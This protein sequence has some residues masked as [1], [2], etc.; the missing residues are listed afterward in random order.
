MPISEP[1]ECGAILDLVPYVDADGYTIQ[2][3]VIPTI[4]EFLGYSA[5]PFGGK[6]GPGVPSTNTPAYPLPQFRLRQVTT[7]AA[8]EDGQT[9]VLGAGSMDAVRKT[10][11]KVPTLGDLPL[12]GRWFQSESTTTN[13]KSLFILITP[14]IID[15]AGNAVHTPDELRLHAGNKGRTGR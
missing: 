1:V 15:P 5:S 12:L 4:R 9:L 6:P 8:I 13:R 7:S 10:K 3:T 14:T 11:D 2:M